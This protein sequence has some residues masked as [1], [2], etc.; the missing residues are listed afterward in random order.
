MNAPNLPDA[1][2]NAP[3]EAAHARGFRVLQGN[4]LAPTE[5][6]HVS[7]LLRFMDP[8]QGAT[9]L[10]IGCGFGEVARLM[11]EERPDLAFI[12]LNRNAVQM[13]YAPRGDGF[14]AVRG[15]MHALPLADASVDG[16][17]FNYALCHAD[18]PVA[19]AEA[20]RVVRPGGF[21]FIYDYERL[22]GDN[23]LMER[24]LC[25][26]AHGRAAF[27]A[28]CK[29]AGWRPVFGIAPGGD[30][31]EFRAL[32]EDQADYDAIFAHLQP[33]IWKME[34][35]DMGERSDPA[36]VLAEA[37]GGLP[38]IQQMA[39]RA[40]DRH[41]RAAVG[42]SGGKDSLACIYLL[43]DQLHRLHVYHMDTGDLLPEVREI[44]EHVKAMCP[45]FVHLRGDVLGWIAEHGMPSDLVSGTA[46][47]LVGRYTCC[48]A[49]LMLPLWERMKAD[50]N[51]LLIR[52]T[53][54]VDLPRL[55]V[56]TG[57]VRDGIEILYPL[58]DW[59][60]AEVFAYLRSVGAPANRIYDHVTNA[61]ECARCPAWLG[62]RRAGYLKQY[63]PAL[64]ADYRD[65]LHAVFREINP[66]LSRMDSELRV[67][68]LVAP[69]TPDPDLQSAI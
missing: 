64:F 48:Y 59:S 11:R 49:N 54:A 66:A 38:A 58:Q 1:V 28:S 26:R 19:L 34:L 45:N 39:A 65:R 8:P 40:L 69:A 47:G 37:A 16:A 31:A 4:R 52:G 29:A 12:L 42:F 21:L 41:E 27:L 20:A 56:A 46:N 18:Q 3:S 57:D 5:A 55:P 50:G 51:T 62:E 44:V 6:E 25:A 9:V 15:D 2:L 30:D 36:A 23:D 33:I 22:S 24:T 32:Y 10:D 35:V 68:S 53:K 60:H 17:M 67:L 63:H 7:A 61:P 13:R 43:R 14:Q